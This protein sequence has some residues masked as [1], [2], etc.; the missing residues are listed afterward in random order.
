MCIKGGDNEWNTR[1]TFGVS[2]E[3]GQTM[4]V[5]HGFTFNDNAFALT[6]SHH[7]PFDEQ[8]LEIGAVNSFAA[9]VYTDKSLKIQEFLFGV[10]DI[11]MGH[12]AEMRVEVWYDNAG[13]IED[14]KVVQNSEVIDRASLSVSTKTSKCLESDTEEKCTTTSMSAVF[15]EPLAD[16]VMAIKAIDFALRDQTTY[17]N[18]GFDISGDSLNPMNTMMIPSLT[19][20][21]GLIEV[22]QNEKY[23]DYWSAQDG[24]IFEMNSHGSFKWIN[25]TFERFQDSGSAYTRVHSD[26][27]KIVDYEQNRATGVFD[28]S[29]LESVLPDSFSHEFIIADRLSA[30]VLAEMII[31]EH[32]AQKVLEDMDQQARWN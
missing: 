20:G 13:E 3:D 19:K 9:T 25:P 31:Q 22:T 30:E 27:G 21:E 11:G 26:F 7:T 16:K 1:P 18:D 28:A 5:G 32:I 12:L 4:V 10:P 17:L 23:S 15:L 29:A 8:T 2:H 14:I 6:D 24:R